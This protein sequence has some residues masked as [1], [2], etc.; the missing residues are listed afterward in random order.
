M[1]VFWWQCQCQSGGCETG[2]SCETPKRR[3]LGRD[4]DGRG[5]DRGIAYTTLR[6][7]VRGLGHDGTEDGE[8]AEDGSEELHLD[9][10]GCRRVV[11][12]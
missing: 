7:V 5:G 3:P 2:H 11:L 9:G 4:A 8:G 1:Q 12:C 10:S 6:Q